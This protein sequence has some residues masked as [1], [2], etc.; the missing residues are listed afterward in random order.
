M[1][2]S[3]VN[4]TK[5]IEKILGI[6]LGIANSAVA[7]YEGGHATV[8]PSAEGPTMA[9]KMF[10]SVVAFTKDGQLLVGESAKRQATTNA[11]GTV[12]EIQR[13]MGTDCKVTIFDKDFT[14]QQISA[15]ILQKI[16]RTQKL[17]SA[18]QSAKQL[19]HYQLTSTTINA[20]PPKRQAK[21]QDSKSCQLLTNPSQHASPTGSTSLVAK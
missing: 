10:P 6:S 21:S 2:E 5:L 1:L 17:T 7:I 3:E 13:K 12:F 15:F 18:V 9:G 19:S 4:K 20:K 16:R 8:I 11:E 14:P